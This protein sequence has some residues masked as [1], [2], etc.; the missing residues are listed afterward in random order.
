V[1]TPRKK[2]WLTVVRRAMEKG[3]IIWQNPLSLT[4]GTIIQLNRHPATVATRIN[5][6]YV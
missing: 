4:S 1:G 2:V 5:V 3:E 6:L